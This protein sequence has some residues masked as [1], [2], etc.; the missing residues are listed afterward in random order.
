MRLRL[1]H[2][3]GVYRR[4]QKDNGSRLVSALEY[5]IVKSE[6]VA[7]ET[8]GYTHLPEKDFHLRE[9][10]PG[11]YARLSE[12]GLYDI[13]RDNAVWTPYNPIFIPDDANF[14]TGSDVIAPNGWYGDGSDGAYILDGTQPAVAGLF[15]KNGSTYTLLKD[16]FF[17][18]LQIDNGI[19]LVPNSYRIYCQ[20]S[21]ILNGTISMNGGNGTNGGN[22]T[23]GVVAVTLALPGTFGPGGRGWPIRS[24]SG[25]LRPAPVINATNANPIHISFSPGIEGA[26]RSLTIEDV[27][28]NTAAN[29]DWFATSTSGG[30]EFN[31]RTGIFTGTQAIGNGAF[32]SGGLGWAW[33]GGSHG[34]GKNHPDNA[35]QG[36]GVLG[37]GY[38]SPGT[39]TG[40]IEP[41]Y[42][43][44]IVLLGVGAKGGGSGSGGTQ[45]LGGGDP[46][47]GPANVG[48]AATS[49]PGSAF[50]ANN[51]HDLLT[52]LLQRLWTH[53]ITG[54]GFTPTDGRARP[55]TL[56]GPSSGGCVG[57]GGAAKSPGGGTSSVSGA[58]GGGGG[59]GAN[60]GPIWIAAYRTSGTGAIESKGGNGGN[61]GNGSIGIADP[62]SNVAVGGGGGG[63]E[64]GG[65][66]GGPVFILTTSMG[67]GITI[68]VTGGLKGTPG[69]GAAGDQHGTGVG[70]P[71][72]DA[73]G[74]AE[75]GFN[76][77]SITMYT[78]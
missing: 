71:G 11:Q 38:I 53:N 52:L 42:T 48:T 7:A 61:G 28:G 4:Q 75:N 76:G 39:M 5:Q 17:T 15:S 68:S 30:A 49:T 46:Q 44:P 51:A 6:L 31:L 13:Y 34:S 26:A 66:C 24:I 27:V 14:I 1:S 47:L 72:A 8:G 35:T 3:R 74:S 64:G 73:P 54:G 57:G 23:P 25:G 70:N 9:W 58:G 78:I 62:V 40:F 45:N 33:C 12:G 55:W 63:G 29:G 21:L 18:T 60:G 36:E 41:L 65:G 19:T 69:V 10:T 16:A 2:A 77:V 20:T 50:G 43:I 56:Y 22:A 37:S 32:V 67:A 59:A